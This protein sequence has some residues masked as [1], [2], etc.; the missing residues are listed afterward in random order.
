MDFLISAGLLCKLGTRAF[1]PT[2]YLA[3]DD[4]PPPPPPKLLFFMPGRRANEFRRLNLV[5]PVK[6]GR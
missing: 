4:V 2:P 6:E 5:F 1:S 3:G